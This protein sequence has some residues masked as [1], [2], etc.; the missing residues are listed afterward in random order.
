MSKY[1]FCTKHSRWLHNNDVLSI[2]GS[3]TLIYLYGFTYL[4]KKGSTLEIISNFRLFGLGSDFHLVSWPFH[5]RYT[6]A[7][8]PLVDRRRFK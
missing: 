1:I 7:L 2:L 5:D 4:Q 6:Y 3:D 8:A